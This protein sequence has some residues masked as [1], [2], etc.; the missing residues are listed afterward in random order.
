M[1]DFE[2]V[3]MV[4]VCSRVVKEMMRFLVV[5]DAEEYYRG[6]E[7]SARIPINIYRGGISSR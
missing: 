3:N 2:S 1:I 5:S 6:A 4:T 7:K